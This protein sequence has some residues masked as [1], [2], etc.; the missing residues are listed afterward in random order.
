ML[1]LLGLLGQLLID[2]SFSWIRMFIALFFSILIS[3]AVGIYAA[4]SERSGRVIVPILDIL[5]TLPIL[6]F[7]PFVIYIVVATLPGYIGINAAVI[8]LIITSMIW[9]ISF[10]V[11]ESIRTLPVQLTEVARLY[12]LTGWQKLT[13]VLIPASMPRVV[14]QSV[15]SWSIGLFYLVTSEIFSTG[16][17]QY[18]VK[19][20]IGVELTK[21]AFS[22]NLAYYAIGLAVFV[23]FV[24]ATRFLFF[25]PFSRRVNRFN[26]YRKRPGEPGRG[27]V[28]MQRFGGAIARLDPRAAMAQRLHALR[29]R[30]EQISTAS[31]RRAPSPTAQVRPTP[32]TKRKYWIVAALAIAALAALLYFPEAGAYELRVLAS[33]AESFVRVW[34]AFAAVLAVAVP[35]S[36]YIVF[37]S[38]H[39]NS[40]LTL[41][42]IVASIPA[43]ILLP[44][45][46]LALANVAFHGELVAFV[47]YF[48]SGIWYVVFSVVASTR[49]LPKYVFEVKSLFRVKGRTALSKIYLKAITPGLITG[50]ITA[51]AA[52]WNASIVA[53]YFTTSAIG[54]GALVSSVH[55]GIGKLLDLSLSS[56]NLTLMFIGLVN[57]TVMII[58]LN[59]FLWKR[60]YRNI[61]KVYG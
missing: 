11:Y 41:F 26:D 31:A 24:I 13:K 14:E 59:T 27:T 12:H 5:Q 48:L 51:I 50:G 16:S 4:R 20:G 45:I 60:L 36:I 28:M 21:L 53:E 61:S 42:Q 35:L 6:A 39:G 54:N 19:Y 46:A 56:G 49:T 55:I 8:F 47:V 57:L 34:V 43:T 23:L 38:K 3:L 22:G 15:L 17:A 9:N 37:M 58:V 18:A 10:G 7:F 44:V 29:Q 1:Q 40:Y 52:E 2:T 33:L 32:H 30:P 25:M